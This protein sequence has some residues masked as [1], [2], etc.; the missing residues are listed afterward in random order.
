MLDVFLTV[1]VEIWCDGW[2]DIDRKFPTAFQQYIYGPTKKGNFG[3]PY[4]LGVL[5]RYGLT[6]VFFVEPLFAAR[7]GEQPLAEIVGMLNE[8][9]QEVQLHLHTEW[10]DEARVPLLPVRHE[11]RQ[12][13]RYFD[14]DEQT[15]LIAQGAALLERAGA[16]RITAFRAGSF[17]FNHD[18][19]PALAANG[20]AF[21]ASYNA[22]M[23]G[24]DS[25]VM[26]GRMMVEPFFDQG[27]IEFPMTVYI[28]GRRSLRHAQITSCSFAEMERL[29]WQAAEQNRAAF[30]IL[31][32]GFEMLNQGKTRPDPIVVDRFERLCRFLDRHRDTFRVRGFR[33]LEPRLDSPTE[34][35]LNIGLKET[36]VRTLQQAYRARYS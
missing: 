35:P 33:G 17:A 22:A 10:V 25:G 21:D 6:G 5:E 36:F 3:L 4:Q 24:L 13:L 28:D 8:A 26:P 23:F 9:D 14:R 2:D 18:T 27:V 30:V 29:L 15:S 11:K 12:H 16:A 19:L 1:D 31:S 7:F 34:A 20:I 32:H